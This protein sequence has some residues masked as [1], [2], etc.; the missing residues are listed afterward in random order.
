MAVQERTLHRILALLAI[1]ALLVG[2]A[3]VSRGLPLSYVVTGDT[4]NP[5]ALDHPVPAQRVVPPIPLEP[6]PDLDKP[7]NILLLGADSREKDDPGRADTIMLVRLDPATKHVRLLSLPRDTRVTIP[8]HG[9]NKLNQTSSGY[10]QG[11]GT[12]LLVDTIT[13]DLLPGL[14][15]DY[16]VK[17]DFAGFAAIIDAL[18]GVTID[19]EERMLY[20]G[21]DVVIDLQPGVQ[22]LDG[23][24]AL[25]YARF[26][27]DAIGD[28]GT[29][30]GQDH[31]RVARQKKL[32]AAVIDQTKEVR[33]L[34]RLPAVIRAVQAAVTTDMS[35]GVM[36]RIAITYKDVAAEGVESVPFPGLPEVVD[37]ISYVI[38]STDVLR[39]TTGPLFGVA[40]SF[41][42]PAD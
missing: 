7:L 35:F 18:G 22:H 19:V 25:E 38:P 5:S 33:T 12:S 29:W 4:A 27:M 24:Q 9:V 28:F 11:G 31:G 1:A 21:V 37:G 42:A 17:T 20:K 8:G 23:E 13:T 30:S 34:L 40:G 16:T 41:E 26:R 3:A 2:V 14:R 6:Q 39:T 10:Y 15:I 36:A 32:L